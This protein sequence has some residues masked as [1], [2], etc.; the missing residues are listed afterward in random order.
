MNSTRANACSVF[1]PALLLLL[2]SCVSHH[3][4]PTEEG[5]I[6]Y[7]AKDSEHTY[8]RVKE[9]AVAM[10]ATVTYSGPV[11]GDALE[12]YYL[13]DA[14]DGQMALNLFVR[15][16]SLVYHYYRRATES[17]DDVKVRLMELKRLFSGDSDSCDSP[18]QPVASV[19]ESA[20]KRWGQGSSDARTD[21]RWSVLPLVNLLG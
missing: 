5:S 13:N 2:T 15:P 19:N 17:P 16:G 9:L 10:D 4:S 11:K 20:E 1:I 14:S 7:C 18:T 3:I 8:E 21:W 12:V 6:R